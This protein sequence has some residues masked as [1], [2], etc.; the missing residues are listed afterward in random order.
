MIS[1]RRSIHCDVA[2]ALSFCSKVKL[3][4]AELLWGWNW[5]V[6]VGDDE[7]VSIYQE[8]KEYF[9]GDNASPHR[10]LVLPRTN[11]RREVGLPAVGE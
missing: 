11:F 4:S 6:A 9:R 5:M 1:G 10:T 3:A 8:K 7:S 2:S